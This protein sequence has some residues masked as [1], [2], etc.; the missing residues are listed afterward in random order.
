MKGAE[1]NKWRIVRKCAHLPGSFDADLDVTPD[2]VH[3]T[4]GASIRLASL[5]NP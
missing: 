5:R 3:L 1:I 4:T 2:I